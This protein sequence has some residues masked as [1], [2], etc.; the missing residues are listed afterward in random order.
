MIKKDVI[1]EVHKDLKQNGFVMN[2]KES[3]AIF[4][5]VIDNITDSIAKGKTVEIS[6]FGIGCEDRKN[7]R[8]SDSFL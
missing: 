6:G 2:R 8:G 3:A 4:D 1:D 7:G 5:I